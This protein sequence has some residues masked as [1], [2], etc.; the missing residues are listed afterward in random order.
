MQFAWEF[1]EFRYLTPLDAFF[2]PAIADI[3]SRVYHELY[4][5]ARKYAEKMETWMKENAKWQNRSGQARRKLMAEPAVAETQALASDM[6]YIVFG[7]RLTAPGRT[8]PPW[9]MFLE[10]ARH[11]RDKYRIVAPALYWFLPNIVADVAS[12]VDSLK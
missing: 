12:L 8:E 2:A 3:D 7:W 4:L 10:H 6:V 11:L 9:G 1:T 5:I